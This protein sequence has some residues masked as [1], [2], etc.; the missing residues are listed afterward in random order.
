MNGRILGVVTTALLAAVQTV[1]AA[2]RSG[3]ELYQTYCSSCNPDGGNVIKPERNLHR[4]SREAFGIRTARDV[5]AR[6]RKP[7]GPQ[8]PRFDRSYLSDGDAQR[9][10]E[11]VVTTF[12]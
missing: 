2:E 10:G 6:M 4:L 5:V 9:I 1:H 11:Y 8:M 7:A 12:Q 3:K